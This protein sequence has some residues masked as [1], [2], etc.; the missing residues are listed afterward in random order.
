M[1]A[2]ADKPRYF[3]ISDDGMRGKFGMPVSRHTLYTPRRLSSSC[4]QGQILGAGKIGGCLH[5]LCL[6]KVLRLWAGLECIFSPRLA[7]F[8]N[9]IPIDFNQN[10]VYRGDTS[11]GSCS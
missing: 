3:M 5:I 4:A 2:T 7:I 9:Q 10:G 11:F 8:K 6:A 1:A